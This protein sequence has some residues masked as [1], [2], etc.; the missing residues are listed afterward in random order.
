MLSIVPDVLVTLIL[1]SLIAGVLGI[2]YRALNG[3]KK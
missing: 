3:N 1:L 2:G